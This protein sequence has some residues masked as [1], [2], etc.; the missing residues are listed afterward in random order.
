M[1][2][3]LAALVIVAVTQS[4][5]IP[6]VSAEGKYIDIT[7]VKGYE[8]V[9][10]RTHGVCS[11]QRAKKWFAITA[12]GLSTV[13]VPENSM[14][15]TSTLRCARR[16]ST[17]SSDSATITRS[18]FST[19]GTIFTTTGERAPWL[20]SLVS[21]AKIPLWRRLSPLVDGTKDPPNILTWLPLLCPGKSLSS[22]PS[23]S[24]R[25]TDSMV[26]IWTGSIRPT[27]EVSQRTG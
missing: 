26:S 8:F 14:S 22:R 10:N 3:F 24:S 19:H 21:R 2:L 13:P 20:A 11:T 16:S 7:S 15:R 25:H 17:V 5:L 12:P 18:G 1:K 27:V 23:T 9:I 4:T 6:Q